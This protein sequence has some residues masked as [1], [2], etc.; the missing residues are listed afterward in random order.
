MLNPGEKL[1]SPVD[2]SAGT[3]LVF[4]CRGDGRT[5]AV[6]LFTERRGQAPS[7]RAFVAGKKWEE[8]RI[9]LSDFD[10]SDGSDVRGIA[11]VAGPT[12]GTY[13][14]QLDDVELR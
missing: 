9:A 3:E 14:F 10:G 6:L 1:F 12:P 5:Y 8:H 7:R 4:S 13:S 2:L 11:F